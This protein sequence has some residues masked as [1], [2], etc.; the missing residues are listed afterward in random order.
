MIEFLLRIHPLTVV[1]P[2]V[3]LVLAAIWAGPRAC[4][5]GRGPT[6]RIVTGEPCRYREERSRAGFV[7]SVCLSFDVPRAFRFTLRREGLYDR[8][9]KAFGI[10]REPQLSH[11]SFNDGFYLDAEDGLAP[12]LLEG[13]PR[14]PTLLA[15]GFARVTEHG[16]RLRAVTCHGGSL[17]LHLRTFGLNRMEIDRTAEEAAAWA[18][19]LLAAMR[20]VAAEPWE[21]ALLQRRALGARIVPFVTF[22]LAIA[23]LTVALHASAEALDGSRD[24]FLPALASGSAAF[25]A[26]VAWAWRRAFP[27]QRHRRALEW[28]FLAWPAFAVLALLVLIFLRTVKVLPGPNEEEARNGIRPSSVPAAVTTSLRPAKAR[29]RARG[30]RTRRRG[31]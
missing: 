26:Y 21:T 2:I 29:P 14:L 22:S 11:E 7:V 4:F 3:A 10:A 5:N 27:A 25:V 15:T 9:A 17:H 1:L 8:F 24:L 28:L 30:S 6:D 20:K 18:S 19:P 12:R 13:S 23:V 16:A 31:Q